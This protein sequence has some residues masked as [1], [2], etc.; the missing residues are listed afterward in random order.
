MTV[1]L[2]A[3]F[4]PGGCP[5]RQFRATYTMTSLS[6]SLNKSFF[7][8]HFA[9]F[10]ILSKISIASCKVQCPLPRENQY[11]LRS[12][13]L[14]LGSI[15]SYFIRF[16]VLVFFEELNRHHCFSQNG[17]THTKGRCPRFPWAATNPRTQPVHDR[18]PA[19][20]V[21]HGHPA[22]NTTPPRQ[23]PGKTSPHL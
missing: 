23:A 4:Y 2:V 13:T 10:L 9:W 8:R 18:S 14:D 21:W 5:F 19:T 20:V 7:I 1:M 11:H 22:A 15:S 6:S 12:N 16:E 3:S 17:T